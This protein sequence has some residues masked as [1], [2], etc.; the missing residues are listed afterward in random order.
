MKRI[1][2]ALFLLCLL[3]PVSVPAHAGRT[4]S[5]GCH[6]DRKNGGYHCHNGGSSSGGSQRAAAP[7]EPTT[8]EVVAVPKARVFIDGVDKGVSPTSR[9]FA[10]SHEVVVELRHPILGKTT[11]RFTLTEG[12]YNQ[13]LVKW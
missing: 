2:R 10:T 3:M 12:S 4:D 5:S 9:M 13:L 7:A 11:Q 8:F 6:N 1:W